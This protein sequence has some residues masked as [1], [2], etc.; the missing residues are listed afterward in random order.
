MIRIAI[1]DDDNQELYHIGDMV[2][3]YCQGHLQYDFE[4]EYFSTAYELIGRIEQGTQF[5]IFLLDIIMPSLNGIELGKQIRLYDDYAIIIYMT[6]STEFAID[7]F[8]V[9]PLNYLVKPVEQNQLVDV[10]NRAIDKISVQ[11]EKIF[12]LRT[13]SAVVAVPYHRISFIEYMNHAIFVHERNGLTLK[14]SQF[15][16]SFRSVMKPLLLDSRF[17]SPHK[18]F[19]VNMD[20]VLTMHNDRYFE[21][22]NGGIIPISATNFSKVKSVFLEYL[23]NGKLV[24]KSVSDGAACDITQL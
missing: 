4:V 9:S 10:L 18:A 21:M 14:S 15:R 12:P 3:Q 6:S 22:K 23:S 11:S 13:K 1:C 17:I 8:S 7:S 19:V 2:T 20:D 5:H 24:K 16:E